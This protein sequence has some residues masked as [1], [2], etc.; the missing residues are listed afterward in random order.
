MTLKVDSKELKAKL[1]LAK[2]IPSKI[3]TKA[4]DFFKA[5]TPIRSG[6]AR[7][8]TSLKNKN[9]IDANYAYAKRLDEG[10]SKQAPQGMVEP[11]VKEIDRLIK[12]ELKK[13]GK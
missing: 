8:R 4:Y 11:T 13:I 1:N 2:D 9:T 12:I 7:S 6:N 5:K 3:M 10:Y